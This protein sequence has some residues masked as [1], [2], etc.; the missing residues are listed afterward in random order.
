MERHVALVSIAKVRA[1]I[2]RPLVGFGEEGAIRI[3]RVNFAPESFDHGMGFRKVFAIGPVP[4]DEI[5]NR[6][7]TQPV[8]PQVQLDLSVSEKIMRAF[9]YFSSVSLHT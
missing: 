5:R 2:S 4:L 6:I 1:H 8:N 3:A 9:L 7:H